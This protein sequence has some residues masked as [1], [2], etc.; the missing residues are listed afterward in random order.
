MKDQQDWQCD[1]RYV[2]QSEAKLCQGKR[3]YLS[4]DGYLMEAY[5]LYL[6]YQLAR[7]RDVNSKSESHLEIQNSTSRQRIRLGW[8]PAR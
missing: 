8:T 4:E 5:R 6:W 2:V 1:F 7:K 3:S